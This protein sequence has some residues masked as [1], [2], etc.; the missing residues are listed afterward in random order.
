MEARICSAPDIP[1]VPERQVT[2]MPDQ[3]AKGAGAD[4][5]RFRRA[6]MAGLVT[7]PNGVLGSP[8]VT[9]PTLG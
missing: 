1:T 8:N 6:L 4:P 9:K 7:S 2:K 3:G 5:S